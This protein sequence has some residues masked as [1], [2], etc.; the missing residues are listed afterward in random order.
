MKI[1]ELNIFR[2]THTKHYCEGEMYNMTDNVKFSDT[3]EDVVRDFNGDGDLLDEGED[4]IYGETAIPYTKVGEYYEVVVSY[5]PKFK[6][7]T[8]EILNVPHFKHIRLHFGATSKN[9]EGCPLMG[10][11]IGDGLLKNTGKTDEL[12]KL[13]KKYDK[14]IL[15][16]R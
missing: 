11:K 2:L 6:K 13:M 12:V 1:L 16:I 5:S 15:K 3:L 9:S 8:A 7:E 14:T 4:K 10:E